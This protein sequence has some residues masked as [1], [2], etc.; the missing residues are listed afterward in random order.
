MNPRAQGGPWGALRG[1]L[2]PYFPLGMGPQGPPG[3]WALF[4]PLWPG[5]YW[6]KGIL[7]SAENGCLPA[8]S[9]A[10]GRSPNSPQ[11]PLGSFWGIVA[12]RGIVAH[13]GVVAYWGIVAHLG[14]CL[15]FGCLPD[16]WVSP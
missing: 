16:I 10:Q 6:P 5:S 4:P 12:Y 13:R 3:P 14:H 11:A 9:G 2:G 15:T 1:P 8:A 7:P